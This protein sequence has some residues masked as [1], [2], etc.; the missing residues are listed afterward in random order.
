MNGRFKG[1]LPTTFK[2]FTAGFCRHESMNSAVLCT[3]LCSGSMTLITVSKESGAE[4][5]NKAKLNKENV[6]P[7]C[8]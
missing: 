1:L 4:K 7:S 8:I 3:F 2:A 5:Q 6:R